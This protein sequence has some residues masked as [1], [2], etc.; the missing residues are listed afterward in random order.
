ML[1]L[2]QQLATPPS[3]LKHAVV[4]AIGGPNSMRPAYTASVRTVVTS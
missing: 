4:T 3:W 1:A 2:K